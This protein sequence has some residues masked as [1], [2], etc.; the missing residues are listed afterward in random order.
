MVCGEFHSDERT[1][2]YNKFITHFFQLTCD[3]PLIWTLVG[4]KGALP[5]PVFGVWDTTN[6]L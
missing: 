4:E 2:R 6:T 5:L 1:D 3:T